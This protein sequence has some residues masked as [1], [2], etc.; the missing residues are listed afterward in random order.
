VGQIL[1][2]TAFKILGVAKAMPLST[3]LQ[4]IL[5]NIFSVTCYGDWRSSTYPWQ[6]MITGFAAIILI[7]VGVI[8]I[9]YKQKTPEP[10]FVSEKV[11]RP[12]INLV[13][14]ILIFAIG[15]VGYLAYFALGE[16]PQHLSDFGLN[17]QI[18]EALQDSTVY[19]FTQ[20]FPQ[21][22]GMVLLAILF[23]FYQ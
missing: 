11:K 23:A 16:L 6:I 1:Q 19:G 3:G 4:L 2:Y 20:F 5:I 14:I 8:A 9:A 7:I 13:Y 18:P 15:T 22:I 12:R 17:Y 10:G 21:A